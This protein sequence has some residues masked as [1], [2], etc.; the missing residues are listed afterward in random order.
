MFDC[1]S[2]SS[3]SASASARAT[4]SNV[5]K[6]Q[7]SSRTNTCQTASLPPRACAVSSPQNINWAHHAQVSCS[8]EL[9]HHP[10]HQTRCSAVAE[11]PSVA[12]MLRVIQYFS[13]LLKVSQSLETA[14]FDILHT[15]SYWRS[16]VIM[17]LSCIIS[18]IKRDIGRKSR[19]FHIPCIR[20]PQLGSWCPSE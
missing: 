5:Y 3:A 16:M 10:L 6:C 4:T 12:S 18:E 8:S 7:E 14:P 15:S 2:D 20:R 17:A 11:R 13:E 1:W 19:F 9:Q